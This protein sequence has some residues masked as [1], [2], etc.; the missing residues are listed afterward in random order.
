MVK[1]SPQDCIEDQSQHSKEVDNYARR[2]TK[3]EQ[4]AR[5]SETD[6]CLGSL[7]HPFSLQDSQCPRGAACSP[8]PHFL[9]SGAISTGSHISIHVHNQY[10]NPTLIEWR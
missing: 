8:S 2:L 5:L 1:F 3:V 7:P 9:S 6:G 4:N 10:S